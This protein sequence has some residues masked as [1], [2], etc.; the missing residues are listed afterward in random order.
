MSEVKAVVSTGEGFENFS[1]GARVWITHNTLGFEGAVILQLDENNR[2][3]I[4]V[5]TDGGQERMVNSSSCFLQ[6]P[7]ILEGVDDMTT[8]S[9]LHE[10]AILHNLETRYAL[11]IIYTYTGSILI[12]VNPFT[13]LHIYGKNVIDTYAGQPLG[14]LSPHVYAISED[15][16]RSMLIDGANQS[17]LV[18]GESGAGKTETTKYL[19]QY[20][21]AMGQRELAMR[22]VNSYLERLKGTGGI[23]DDIEQRVLESTPLLEAF[24]NAKTIRNDNSSRFGKFIEVQFDVQGTIVGAKIRTYLLE[25]SRIARQ[26]PDERSYHIFYQLASD[27]SDAALKAGVGR[28]EGYNYIR[29]CI[30]VEGTDDHEQFMI[31]RRAMDTV[32]IT[33][34]E[35][36]DVFKLLSGVLSLGNITFVEDSGGDHRDGSKIKD[37]KPLEDAVSK[38]GCDINMLEK[39]LINKHITA[40]TEQ[41]D[42]PLTAEKACTTRD[43]LSMILYSKMFDWIVKRINESTQSKKPVKNTIGVLDIY[44]FEVFENNSF[45]QLCINYANEKLQQQFNQYIF[46]LEQVEYEKEKIDWSYIEF[47]DNQECLDLLDKKP[48][49]IF[50]LLDEQSIFPRATPQLLTENIQT[51]TEKYNGT[52]NKG[53]QGTTG[54][55]RYYEKPRWGDRLFT[56]IH[57]AGKVTYDTET[58]IDKNKDYIVPEHITIMERSTQ[59]FVAGLFGNFFKNDNQQQG[60]GSGTGGGSKSSQFVS[61][62]T[63]FKDSLNQL[64]DSIRM[65]SPH[66]IRCIKPNMQKKPLL[67]DKPMVLS[68]LRSG[69]VL[70]CIRITKAGYPTRK[71]Y[72]TFAPR[73]KI[74]AVKKLEELRKQGKKYDP[75][76]ISEMIVISCNLPKNDYQLGTTKLFLRAGQLARFE[77][78]RTDLMN[79]SAANLQKVWRMKK[80]YQLYQQSKRAALCMQ[81]AFRVALARGK[82]QFMRK[83]FAAIRIQRFMR[84]CMATKKTRAIRRAVLT[85]Q[86]AQREGAI[87]ALQTAI[88]GA[89][90]RKWFEKYH[91]RIVRIQNRWRCKVAW[92]QLSELRIEA[93]SINRILEEKSQ[94]EKKCEELEWR[95]AAESL[96]RDKLERSAVKKDKELEELRKV[97]EEK[98]EIEIE[99]N[100]LMRENNDLMSELEELRR[101]YERD[102][103]RDAAEIASLRAQLAAQKALTAERE[104]EIKRLKEELEGTKGRLGERES[105]LSALREEG[106]RMQ[107]DIASLEAENLE[108]RGLAALL[109]ET[110][111]KGESYKAESEKLH[112]D[113]TRLKASLR[114]HE[115]EIEHMQAKLAAAEEEIVKLN[116]KIPPA[117]TGRPRARKLSLTPIKMEDVN[118]VDPEQSLKNAVLKEVDQDAEKAARV[119]IEVITNKVTQSIRNEPFTVFCSGV[120]LHAFVIYRCYMLD[121]PSGKSIP[122]KAQHCAYIAES[123]LRTV[124]SQQGRD[125]ILLLSY[126]V[127]SLSLLLYL[128]RSIRN[129]HSE[130]RFIEGAHAER[131]SLEY[132]F[133]KV[134]GLLLD[135]VH[136]SLKP[137]VHGLLD[138]GNSGSNITELT[139]LVNSLAQNQVSASLSQQIF[140]QVFHSMNASAFNEVILRRDLCTMNKGLAIK[141]KL[142][143]LRQWAKKAEC[144]DWV[145]TCDKELDPLFQLGSVLSMNKPLIV[146][147]DVR[148][149]LKQVLSLY[150]PD[151]PYEQPVPLSVLRHLIESKEY[152]IEDPICIE[153]KTSKFSVMPSSL[154]HYL[155]VTDMNQVPF[156]RS[157]ISMVETMLAHHSHMLNS[158]QTTQKTSTSES[159]FVSAS[160][161]RG[162]ERGAFVRGSVMPQN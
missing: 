91:K 55:Y 60:K 1:E 5:L 138:E 26:A 39:Y 12:A 28:A 3:A 77:K 25:K 106:E 131:S 159:K 99:R 7:T 154:L 8:L 162:G 73:Y 61:V 107:L 140:H 129:D 64:M 136:N 97:Q 34:E 83:I 143:T 85:L 81:T 141:M 70:E 161:P 104:A 44:G 111:K 43:A 13:K 95:L 63:Q 79:K 16:F 41:Y 127:S 58:F 144:K 160:A 33:R 151:E 157:L 133:I 72:E 158:P 113:N 11:S 10:P 69:G 56:I 102:T 48:I 105:E 101:K 115:Q 92:R 42:V 78:M 30:Q 142:G 24:G 59:A 109:E 152:R 14:K 36:A 149:E 4:K 90:I 80:F 32:G 51:L 82:A 123:V 53:T 86:T 38:L 110:K 22:G 71:T 18:S 122:L 62:A 47:A 114:S 155:S 93:R 100:D 119:L 49:S 68:Q 132:A 66:Y 156:Q 31:T 87:I 46:K 88:R 126:W 37:R 76:I 65:T 94:L 20:F 135:H 45:E 128:Q 98:K 19:L 121:V 29:S 9:Y 96:T 74:L 112:A 134:Y 153:I 67:F 21:A 103:E 124:Q 75:R 139:R 27:E 145:G 130:I 125:D 57:Y 118:P 35:Q 120:P 2:E 137:M 148:D 50:S 40:G 146:G 52:F 6:N 54:I 147:K 117:P 23:K 17:I 15:A 116:A 89:E 84:K 150:Q 108:N